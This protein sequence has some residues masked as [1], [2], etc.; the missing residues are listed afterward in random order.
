MSLINGLINASANMSFGRPFSITNYS[1]K[2]S[3]QNKYN[4][5]WKIK[6][7]NLKK[8]NQNRETLISDHIIKKLNNDYYKH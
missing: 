1:E 4:F 5:W 8:K 7:I 3:N 6:F 2:S